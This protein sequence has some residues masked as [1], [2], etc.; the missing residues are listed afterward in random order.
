[1]LKVRPH[2]ILCIRA[3]QGNGYSKEF[4]INMESI[5][6]EIKAYN[7]FLN[8]NNLDYELNKVE[9]VFN[10]DS[11]CEKCPNKLGENICYTQ[12]KVKLLDLKIIRYFNIKEGIHNYKEL[13]KM[14]YDNMTEDVFNDICGECSWYN[15]ANCKDYIL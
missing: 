14:V 3:Y 8:V 12:E 10:T 4:S 7:S 6:K 9:I 5:I 2:H 11:I 13:E 1:M 15:T